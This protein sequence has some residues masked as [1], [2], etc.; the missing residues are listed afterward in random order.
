MMG[1]DKMMMCSICKENIAVVFITKILDGK[2]TQEGLCFSCAR[3]QGIQPIKQIIEQTGISEEEMEDLNK[4]M[5]N[6]FEELDINNLGSMVTEP[7]SGSSNPFL[8][9]FNKTLFKNNE[10]SGS[11]GGE[12]KDTLDDSPLKEDREGKNNTRTKTHDKK[13]PKKKKYLDTYGTNLNEKA[14]EGKID[15]VIGRDKEI[16]RVIQILNRRNKNN[17][18]LIGEPG[19]GKTAI[20]EGLAV[21]IVE[22][23]VPAKL[24]NTEV[25]QLDLTSIVAGTQFRGQFESRMKGI[26]EEAK[27]FGNIIL[28]IDELHNIMGAGEAEGAMN[29][30]NILK[31]ALAK[32]EI[33]VIGA[34]TLNEYRKHIEKDSA[35]E[36]RFQPVMVDE[37]S[38]EETI[39]ILKGIKD[40]YESY[41]RVKIPDEV[42]R[43][44]VIMSE[45]Y[46]TD[47]F[48]PDKAIDVIDEA[49]SRAN[50]NNVSLLEYDMLKEELKKV[51]EEK[52]NAISADSIEDYQKAADLKVRECKLIEKI[53]EIEKKNKAL[54]LTIDDVAHVIESWT[55]IPV[56]R[57]TEI[58]AKKLLNLEERLH[59]RIIGQKHAVSSVAK[60][61]RRN[62]ADFKRK[63]RPTSFIFVGPTGVGKT[64]LVKAL[65]VEL[66][67]SEEALIRLDMSEYMEKHTVSKMIGAPPGYVGYDDGGQLTEKVRRKPYSVI[68]LDEIEKAHPDVFNMLLQILED[69][70]VTDSHGRTVSFE[71]T[72]IIMTSNAGTSL[73]AHGI[74]F[75]NDNYIALENK[76][77]EVLKE[78]FRPE[79]LNRID[80]IIV[81]SEL[82]RDELKQIVNLMLKEVVEEVENKGIK[83]EMTET[84]QDYILK[85]GY[86]QK[87]GARPLRRTI[88][89]YIEDE[90]VDRYL[91]GEYKE[92]SHI[93][94]DADS[95]G[96]I[97]KQKSDLQLESE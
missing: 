38:V 86:D 43:A 62:R 13:P 25:Y 48:L 22:K 19:V 77:N 76:V 58:E 7:G 56:Q 64:E 2:Q 80:E 78:T 40:Y 65:A 94:I 29:A 18:V 53:N 70:R 84:V 81:F 52:E 6:F 75:A 32:G 88:Q 5:G 92:G 79:F 93:V 95:N 96:L 33:Q 15:R 24:F 54:E 3:K 73:K 44:A 4:Q 69:G 28:V 10:A 31:P 9:F 45:R 23:K 21:R 39:E 30:G 37:P 50:I 63:K 90:L 61:I 97:F 85:L 72:I 11:K 57:L 17:P 67:E 41:H 14:K 60:A 26:I 55:K 8:N 42:I 20:A 34:T 47:R 49:G 51:Q 1:V 83:I 16:D 12:S 27:H 46:I 91:R 82:N 66:F 71:N 74:G 35:L 87:Y 36:R 68:L 59:K 89:K